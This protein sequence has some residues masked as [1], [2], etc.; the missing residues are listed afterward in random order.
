L[1]PWTKG[2]HRE[3][4]PSLDLKSPL[5]AGQPLVH[6][7]KDRCSG[8][9]V[10]ALDCPYGAI[11]MVERNDGAPHK[12]IAIEDPSLCVSCGICVGSCDDVAVTLGQI[13]S[14]AIWDTVAGRLAL[15][16][17]KSPIDEVQVVFTCERHG[18]HGG[19]S[20]IDNKFENP[21]GK[22]IE[23]ITL[24]CV[25]SA[26]PDLLGR[27][28]DEGVANVHIID[29]P[30]DDCANCEGNIWLEQ[31]ITRE[32]VPRLKRPYANAPI[33]GSWL[34]PNEFDLGLASIPAPLTS[35]IENQ[36][37]IDYMAQ[38]QMFNDLTWNNYMVAFFLLG[39]VM[40]AQVFLTSLPYSPFQE[41]Y[42]S[43]QVVIADIGAPLG[44]NSYISSI[45]GPSL[46]LQLEIDG[47]VVM[48][49]LIQT[50]S[51][52]DN[53]DYP[54]FKEFRIIP[55]RQKVRLSLIDHTTATSFVYF[56]APVV[57]SEG[58]LITIPPPN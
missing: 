26:P 22:L 43:G 30:A 6:I 17:L 7:I 9:T 15:A 35:D 32:R 49:D 31:R 27:T 56:D 28:L 44:R 21:N 12:Y 47:E 53:E 4:A 37:P 38:R 2:R 34:P 57:V 41:E 46:A 48:E 8:C 36:T 3:S 42:A 13:P 40:I 50:S 45:L 1:L 51:I 20:Y 10:C 55:G 58:D 19:R 54:Y 25:G 33:T 14:M 52:L 5:S 23:V 18:V 16:K 39:L 24:P 29:C 11:E